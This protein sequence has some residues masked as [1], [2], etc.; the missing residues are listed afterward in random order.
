MSTETQ[1]SFR[2]PVEMEEMQ[3]PPTPISRIDQISGEFLSNN[4]T[5]IYNY[6]QGIS[7]INLLSYLAIILGVLLISTRLTVKINHLFGLSIGM[8]LV[9]YLNERDRAINIDDLTKIEVQME[10]ITPKPKYFYM[11]ANL[12]ELVYNLLEFHVHNPEDFQSM[13]YSIDNV[14]KLRLDIEM[15]MNECGM[16]YDVAVDQKNRALNSLSAILV[17]IPAQQVLKDK[18]VSGIKILQLY[19]Q[20][21]VDFIH[22]VCDKQN[23]RDGIHAETD[24][25]PTMLEKPNKDILADKYYVY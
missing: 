14:L 22:R 24:F 2:I 23:K 8:V 21:H 19:L 18:L 5:G 16:I 6:L 7:G 3:L 13:V 12:I 1:K 25:I 9:Y 10:S 4:S 15:G 11:D 20:R 17:S